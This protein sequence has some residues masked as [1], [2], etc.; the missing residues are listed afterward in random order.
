VETTAVPIRFQDSSAHLVFIRDITERKRSE[1]LLREREKVYRA[2]VEQAAEGILLIDCETLRFVEFNDAACHRLGYSRA[3]FAELTL[4]DLQGILSSDE[5]IERVRTSMKAGHAHFENQQRRKDGT[6]RDVLISNRVINVRGRDH[7]VA[8]WQD[9]TERKRMEAEQA[10]AEAQL[11]QAQKMEAIGTLAGG[12]AH[13]FNNILGIIIGYAEIASYAVPKDSQVYV[14]LDQVRR[15]ARRA[16]DLVRQILAFSRQSK[17]ERGPVMVSPIVKE[18][19]KLLRA[20]LPSTIE[21]RENVEL[22]PGEDTILSEPTQIHQVLM[23]LCTNAG[24]AMRE[25][26]GVLEV[27][28]SDVTFEPKGVEHQHDLSPGPYLKLTISDTG[29]GID[30][31]VISRIFEPYFTTKEVGEGTGLGLAVVHGIVKEHGGAVTVRSEL[32]RGTTFDVFFPKIEAESE[33]AAE[34][35]TILPGGTE[36]ILYVDDEPALVEVG[37]KILQSLDYKVT[38]RSSSVEALEAFRSQ[39]NRFEMIITDQIMPHMTGLELAREIL[40]IRPGIPIIICTGFSETV[41]PE[42]AEELG[43]SAVVMKPLVSSQIAGRIRSILD[44]SKKDKGR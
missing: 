17:E 9:I 1:D 26:G 8:I 42:R 36:S 25:K 43:V 22:R 24:H 16:T 32:E 20:S 23:N 27:S 19:L 44:A 3:E 29:H 12:I 10:R 6:L 11:K 34:V 7:I 21:I 35:S 33:A 41:T 31:A 15:A 5:V 4:F 28:L 40:T 30:P 39:P 38:S 18:G 13:D 2:I 14:N 37:T